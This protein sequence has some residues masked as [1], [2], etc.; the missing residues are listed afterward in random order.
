MHE[1]YMREAIRLAREAVTGDQGGP[2]GA[3]VVQDG[4]VVGR[5]WNRVTAE[6]DPTAHAEVVAIRDA[7]ARLGSYWLEGCVLYVNCEPC[8]MC[9]GAIYWARIHKVYYAGVAAD[10]AAI[11]FADADIAQELCRPIASRRLA[12]E[13]LLRAEALPVFRLWEEKGDRLDY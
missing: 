9:L 5:G 6:N 2:F 1:E 12:M 4:Q 8:P 10:A 11:G 7:C 13:Q 3:V